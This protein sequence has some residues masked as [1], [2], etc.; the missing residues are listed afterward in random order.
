MI[1]KFGDTVFLSSVISIRTGFFQSTIVHIGKNKR[2]EVNGFASAL[3]GI[4][5]LALFVLEAALPATDGFK[6]LV[7]MPR[8]V[9]D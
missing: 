6:Y 9:W 1:H 3:I 7:L 5:T 4:V 2:C 8:P